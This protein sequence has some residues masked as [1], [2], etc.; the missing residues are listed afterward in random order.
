MERAPPAASP[1]DCRRRLGQPVSGVAQGLTSGPLTEDA[2]G[3]VFGEQHRPTEA[4]DVLFEKLFGPLHR[5]MPRLVAG[6]RGPDDVDAECR[7]VAQALSVQAIAFRAARITLLRHPGQ[8]VYGGD[9]AKRIACL[10][11]ALTEAAPDC[12]ALYSNPGA[13]R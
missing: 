1:A 5:L 6:V 4:F 2:P 8:D 13:D 11:Q 9:D 10:L 3:L 12:R 7:L